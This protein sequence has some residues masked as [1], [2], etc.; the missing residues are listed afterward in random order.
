MSDRWSMRGPVLWAFV[1]S[2]GQR[3]MALVVTLVLASILGPRAYGIV[4]IAIVFIALLQVFL[5]Q[6]L[7]TA[8]I[9]RDELEPEH[10]DAAFWLNLVWALALTLLAIALSG[11]W[12]NL[13]NIPELQLVIIVLAPTLLFRGLTMIQQAQLQREYRFKALAVRTNASMF[14]SGVVGLALAFGGAGIWALVAQQVVYDFVSVVVLWTASRWRPRFSYSSRH[15]RE[16]LGYSVSVF[17]ANLGGFLNRRVDA[18]LIGAFF[19]PAVVGV[20]RLSDRMVDV[21]LEMTSRP[22]GS[23]A[24]P[25]FSRLQND[26]KGLSSSVV[27]AARLSLTVTAPPLLVI[28]GCAPW[29]LGAVGEDWTEG[30]LALR[31]L[32]IVGIVKGLVSFVGPV[33]FAVNRPRLR[34]GVSWT[35]AG[36]SALSVLIAGTLLEGSSSYTQLVG[37]S[38][39][40]ALVFLCFVAPLSLWAVLSA[41]PGLRLRELLRLFRAPLLSGGAA[42]GAGYLIQRSGILDGAPDRVALLIVGPIAAGIAVGCLALTDRRV[43]RELVR[44]AARLRGRRELGHQ[45]SAA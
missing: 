13:M 36:I 44:I 29:I 25:R 42:L 35:L 1:M 23:V 39:S 28:A 43:R 27:G 6:G 38:A 7:N 2:W 34:A 22:I 14:T 4:A 10:V 30:A 8:V 41:V 15:G 19:G 20:Y 12:S 17:G 24:L 9:Q 45:S 33:L 11:P 40:R 31:L 18:L 16:L 3:I 5:E 21:V 26:P 32:C 37:M